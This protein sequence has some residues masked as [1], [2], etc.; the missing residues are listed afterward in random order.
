MVPS[1]TDLYKLVLT[2]LPVEVKYNINTQDR[3]SVLPRPWPYR[4][5]L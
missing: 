2:Y 1:S 4:S 3:A 5:S